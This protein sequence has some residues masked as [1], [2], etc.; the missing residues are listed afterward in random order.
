MDAPG[1]NP[2]RKDR[3]IYRI[4]L[5]IHFLARLD[6]FSTCETSFKECAYRCAPIR[7]S[8]QNN[9]IRPFYSFLFP[10]LSPFYKATDGYLHLVSLTL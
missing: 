7:A 1:K 9:F 2:S 3:N 5:H 4:D 6:G 10:V 8:W